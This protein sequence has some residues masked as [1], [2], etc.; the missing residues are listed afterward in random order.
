MIA[1]NMGVSYFKHLNDDNYFRDQGHAN[2]WDI[3]VLRKYRDDVQKIFDNAL[4]SRSEYEECFNH[5]NF[6]VKNE[7]SSLKTADFIKKYKTYCLNSYVMKKEDIQLVKI[8]AVYIY[9]FTNMRVFYFGEPILKYI[10]TI[11]DDD[12]SPSFANYR[13]DPMCSE[14][15]LL[16]HDFEDCVKKLQISHLEYW[17]QG[18]SLYKE[19]YYDTLHCKYGFHALIVKELLS[20]IDSSN[21]QIY[22]A[23]WIGGALVTFFMFTVIFILRRRKKTNND[24][25]TDVFCEFIEELPQ[26]EACIV[27]DLES[28]PPPP[29]E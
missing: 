29:Y 12:F 27:E 14:W 6:K 10:S 3:N 11:Y 5:Y 26:Y 15:L 2:T 23:A 25:V 4:D 9:L 17:D 28:P 21:S 22:R 7:Y 13:G 16:L 20:G 18:L 24:I 8:H 19:K 1:M